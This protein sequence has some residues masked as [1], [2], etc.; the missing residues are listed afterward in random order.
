MIRVKLLL[1][2]ICVGTLVAISAPSAT[3]CATCFGASDSPMAKGM[4]WGIFSLL[5]VIVCMLSVIASFF[6]FLSKKSAQVSSAAASEQP[7]ET[8]ND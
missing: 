1:V 5:T 7:S 3:A 2:S 4:N 6:V 8:K